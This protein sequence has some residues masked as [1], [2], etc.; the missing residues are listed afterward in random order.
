MPR[1]QRALTLYPATDCAAATDASGVSGRWQLSR[2]SHRP[3]LAAVWNT[4]GQPAS[5]VALA[6][7]RYHFIHVRYRTA[8]VAGR[9]RWLAC[10]ALLRLTPQVTTLPMTLSDLR[11][12]FQLPESYLEIHNT[13]HMRN[14]LTRIDIRPWATDSTNVQGWKDRL[15]SL[16]VAYLQFQNI[17]S[18]YYVNEQMFYSCNKT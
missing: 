8:A 3:P 17:S 5:A 1:S 13:Y 16:A 2:P 18:P 10:A 6:M 9:A 4:A 15:K 12:S 7:S 11:M 14:S